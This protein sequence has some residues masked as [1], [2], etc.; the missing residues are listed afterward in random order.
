[1]PKPKDKTLEG[2]VMRDIVK[3]LDKRSIFWL[4][5]NTE[6]TFRKTKEGWQYVP[7]PYAKVGTPDMVCFP[8]GQAVFLELKRP[9]GGRLSADQIAMGNIIKSEGM[10]WYC[11]KSVEELQSI[12]PKT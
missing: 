12:L 2:K 1:M 6:G 9:K 5:L 4:R 8:Q 10:E 3:E 7:S 11:I